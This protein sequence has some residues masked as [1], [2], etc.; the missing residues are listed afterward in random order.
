MT[1]HIERPSSFQMVL[2]SLLAFPL[3]EGTH[4]GL[5]AAVERGPSQGA[6]S[7]STGP[8]WVSFPSFSPYAFC[9]QKRHL[10]IPSPPPSS[11]VLSQG[12]GLI[13]LPLRASNEGSARPRVARAQ[14]IIR[15]H[16]II[17]H[18]IFQFE[19]GILQPTP[20][21]RRPQPLSTAA[22]H[23]A[24][25]F[26]RPNMTSSEYNRRCTHTVAVYD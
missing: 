5:R 3:L 25:Q 8:T 4:V 2:P 1:A 17:P 24:S 7:G 6:R 22:S 10:T 21:E 23:A 14:K 9:E 20:V 18:S 19:H 16:P 15:L 26:A 11:L 12:W 13:D